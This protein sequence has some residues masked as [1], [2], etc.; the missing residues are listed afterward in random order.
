MTK[1]V[2]VGAGLLAGKE[3]L[4]RELERSTPSTEPPSVCD[5]IDSL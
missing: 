2:I 3:R 5:T 4:I 1:V